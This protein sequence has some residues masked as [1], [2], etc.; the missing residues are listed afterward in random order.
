M[1]STLADDS[2]ADSMSGLAE[3]T[4]AANSESEMDEYL[5]PETLIS[6]YLSLQSQILQLQPD[7]LAREP[8][9][10]K[11]RPREKKIQ[12]IPAVAK[13]LAKLN[14]I[15][16]DVLFDEEEAYI[17]W[18][19]LR[20]EIAQASAERRKYY[21][22]NSIHADLAAA[23]KPSSRGA[24]VIEMGEDD[25][26]LDMMGDLFSSLPE[27]T[28]DPDTGVSNL[29]SQD[30]VGRTVTIRDFGRWT[31]INPRRVLEEACKARLDFLR[32]SRFQLAHIL[33]RDAICKV[34]YNVIS[35]STF[36]FQH[37]LLIDWSVSQNLSRP[38]Y[39]SSIICDAA[40]FHIKFQMR[41]VSTPDILQSESYIST[42]ALYLI[43][44]HSPK[45]EKAYL[46]LP[47]QWRDLWMEMSLFE[48]EQNDVASRA[49]L[50]QLQNIITATK[51][52]ANMPQLC[53]HDSIKQQAPTEQPGILQKTDT[54][55]PAG[56]APTEKMAKLWFSKSSSP[57][58]REMLKS[59][60]TLPI[61]NFKHQ[62]LKVIE[63]NQVVI[64]CGETGC[65]K[66][67]QVCA[68]QIML[69]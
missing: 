17:R 22:D 47:P 48:R 31:G 68:F 52:D 2:K 27:I 60:E 36:S 62:L 44:G 13:L 10:S 26:H 5:E 11:S 38:I 59:R 9:N 12:P 49:D 66:S 63:D 4:S 34:T 65:G 67:T 56:A 64:V 20:D 21:L 39:D 58:Y 1:R 53:A 46:R 42:A 57:M 30:V 61:W 55:S 24:A 15:K 6:K 7:F 43:F 28:S 32:L 16:S 25:E 8:T 51:S 18:A 54:K 29:V 41:T 40:E 3:N 33:D 35:E 23:V 50:R 19:T 14:K 69:R 45:E 37:S